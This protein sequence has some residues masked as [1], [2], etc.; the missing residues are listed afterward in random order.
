[1]TTA[2]ELIEGFITTPEVVTVD[3]FAQDGKPVDHF[4]AHGATLYSILLKH[5]GGWMF[6][7]GELSS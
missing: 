4:E 7:D 2:R 5:T 3:I 1:M 6:E